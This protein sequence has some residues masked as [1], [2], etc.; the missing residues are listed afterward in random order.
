MQIYFEKAE[1]LLNEFDFIILRSFGIYVEKTFLIA[2]LLAEKYGDLK[3]I[4]IPQTVE[5]FIISKQGEKKRSRGAIAIQL[6]RKS[7]NEKHIGYQETNTN[8]KKQMK[9]EYKQK[10]NSGN[11]PEKTAQKKVT[12]IQKKGR[13]SR[14]ISEEE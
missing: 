10:R 12:Y 6:S 1:G 4:N 5:V 3:Q 7:L 8:N 13:R 11:Y 9:I 2:G 14:N